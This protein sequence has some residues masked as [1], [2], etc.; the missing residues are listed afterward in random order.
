MEATSRFFG[1]LAILFS[2]AFL[3]GA[4]ALAQTL[5][6]S[7]NTVTLPSSVGD[8][9]AQ[10]AVTSSG[11]DFNFTLTQG[12]ADT[13]YSVTSS[14]P[15]TPATLTIILTRLPLAA[16]SGTITLTHTA[17]DI[18][19][20]TV[21]FVPG[22]GGG[23]VGTITASTNQLT[24]NLAF[25]NNSVTSPAV[26]LSTASIN[27]VPFT[28]SVTA[29][30][31]VPIFAT[32]SVSPLFQVSASS[33]AS[34]TVTSNSAGLN[35]NT[36]YVNTITISPTGGGANTTITVTL[37]VGTGG[38]GG[39]YQVSPNIVNFNYPT[40]L[41]QQ[42]VNVFSNNSSVT[43]FNATAT[44]SNGWLILSN[45]LTQVFNQAV[46]SG[47]TLSVNSA[48]ALQLTT[49]TIS[50]TVTLYNPA[51]SSDFTTI[52][53]YLGVNSG[54]LFNLSLNQT[55][56][57]FNTVVNGGQLQ[58]QLSLSALNGGATNYFIS[59]FTGSWLSASANNSTLP[60]TITVTANPSG[61]AA[62][63]YNGSISVSFSGAVT[64]VQ[65]IPVTLVVGGTGTP[66]STIAAP[67]TLTFSYQVNSGVSIPQQSVTVNG[68]GAI[69]VSVS[70]S[71]NQNWLAATGTSSAPGTVVVYVIPGN[72]GAG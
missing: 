56:I 62:S 68:T 46:S 18:K 57:L 9:F 55:S 51:N 2:A 28:V 13:W 44:S 36:T 42:F 23:S 53:V 37:T 59:G 72:L 30:S 21:N 5:V 31:G 32:T 70:T 52:T 24:P 41:Q 49:G 3:I 66:G 65:T 19:T 15:S 12:A 69:S 20:I 14:S 8:Q 11:T 71:G 17:S 43:T 39:S 34:L 63:T 4:P 61:L 22:G 67:T 1:K 40:G 27:T 25:G 7:T 38:T 29:A 10:V 33:P 50:G 26:T 60:G 64:G 48:A 58:S 47:L 45:G 54:T 16:T 6:V 35:N